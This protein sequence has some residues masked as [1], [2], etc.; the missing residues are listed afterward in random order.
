MGFGGIS[1]TLKIDPDGKVVLAK[2]LGDAI[3]LPDNLKK[4]RPEPMNQSSL[5]HDWPSLQSCAKQSA[6]DG[7][8]RFHNIVFAGAGAAAASAFQ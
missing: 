1:L 6:E 3:H 8:L 7:P 4:R 2:S 5:F